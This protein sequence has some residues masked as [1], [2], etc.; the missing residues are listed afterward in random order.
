MIASSTASMQNS[1]SIEIDTRQ[2]STR[3]LYQ[4]ITAVR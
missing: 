2:A 4:S 3:R 1:V